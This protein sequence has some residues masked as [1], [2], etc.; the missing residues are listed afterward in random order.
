MNLG[1]DGLFETTTILFSIKFIKPI[2]YR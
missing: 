1:V 2:N